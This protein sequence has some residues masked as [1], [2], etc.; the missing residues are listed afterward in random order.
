MRNR[1][2]G[3]H[4]HVVKLGGFLTLDPE[5]E[6]KFSWRPNLARENTT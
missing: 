3:K 2:P 4:Q 6:G 1:L 5:L